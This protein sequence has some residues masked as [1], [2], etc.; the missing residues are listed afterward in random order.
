MLR[1]RPVYL[2]TLR[3]KFRGEAIQTRLPWK[4]WE[5]AA[6]P[7]VSTADALKQYPCISL[8]HHLKGKGYTLGGRLEEICSFSIKG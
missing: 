3:V 1:E 4:E 8:V 6:E 5:G 2:A 7:I